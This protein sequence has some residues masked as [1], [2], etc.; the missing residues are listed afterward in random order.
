MNEHYRHYMHT[1]GATINLAPPN[2]VQK[3]LLRCDN[4]RASKL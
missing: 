3:T 4:L 1:I 2:C